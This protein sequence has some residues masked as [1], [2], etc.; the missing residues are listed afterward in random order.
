MWNDAQFLELLRGPLARATATASVISCGANRRVVG[1]CG[2]VFGEQDLSFVARQF[3]GLANATVGQVDPID[4]FRELSREPNPHLHVTP[5]M[6]GKN[7]CVAS[8]Y[9]L[10]AYLGGWW[11]K[12]QRVCHRM[13]DSGEVGSLSL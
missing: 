7:A 6:P 10:W 2:P 3:D 11:L 4:E 5:L 13:R 9:G 12:E 1:W 8:P